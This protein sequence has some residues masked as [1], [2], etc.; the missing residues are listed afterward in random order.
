[1]L[2]KTTNSIHKFYRETIDHQMLG[3][4]N[5]SKLFLISDTETLR[6]YYYKPPLD[7][8]LFRQYYNFLKNISNF[9]KFPDCLKFVIDLIQSL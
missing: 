8:E 3:V 7:T 6:K 9:L 1:M 2:L 4:I 5:L